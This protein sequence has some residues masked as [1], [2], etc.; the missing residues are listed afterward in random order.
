MGGQKHLLVWR[1]PGNRPVLIGEDVLR[2]HGGT[3]RAGETSAEPFGVLDRRRGAEFAA[4][5]KVLGISLVRID[6]QQSTECPSRYPESLLG[7][8]ESAR[9]V[10]YEYSSPIENH[11]LDQVTPPSR[12]RQVPPT[13]TRMRQGP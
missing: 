6:P 8:R 1:Q 13:V 5:P 12:D 7:G 10:P 4:M 3:T 9:D 2:R 11:D